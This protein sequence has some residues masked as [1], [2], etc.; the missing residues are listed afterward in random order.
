M[1]TWRC[2]DADP[3]PARAARAA[4]TLQ[5]MPVSRR[6]KGRP[7]TLIALGFAALA[8]LA[9]LFS[10][11]V[12]WSRPWG[13]S[14]SSQSPVVTCDWV[15]SRWL[16]AIWL[17]AALAICVISLRRWALPLAAISLPLIAFSVISVLGVFTLAPAALW[18][19]CALW[20]WSGNRRL[21]ITLTAV[22]SVPLLW[23]GIVGVMGLVYLAGAPI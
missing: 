16:A 19:A 1:Q 23:F 6:A 15:T 14:V 7:T 18:L 13:C 10:V 20:L 9:A 21:W 17:V 2:G 3:R 8:L 5:L 22:A 11:F 12:M 4:H